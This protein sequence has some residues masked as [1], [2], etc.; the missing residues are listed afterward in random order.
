MIEITWRDRLILPTLSDSSPQSVVEPV[1]LEDAKAF[2]RFTSDSENE[3]ILGWITAARQHFEEQTGRPI[4]N[5]QR[6]FIIA[7]TPTNTTIQIPRAPLRSVES[8][9]AVDE[10]GVETA[11]TDFLVQP[12]MAEIGS[13]AS[14][15][16]V[17]PHAPP[18]AVLLLGSTVWPTVTA[19]GSIRI[20][21]T[22][23]YGERDTDVPKL[24]KAALFFLIGH[25]H[26]NRLEVGQEQFE[27]PVGAR[28]MIRAFRDSAKVTQVLRAA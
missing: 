25:F 10:D 1:S 2:L 18:G 6:E 11:F 16:Y 20:R 8:I 13:P 17:D 24:I 27:T 23:G 4:I 19:P 5:Q 3:L 21:Y 26:R 7:G 15:G 9:V 28:T 14:P 12:S 22:A